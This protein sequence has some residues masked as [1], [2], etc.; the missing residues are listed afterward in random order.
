MFKI[1]SHNRQRCLEGSNK[2][3]CTAG[4]GDPTETEPELCVSVS[5]GGTV[6][7][8]WPAIGAGAV[9]LG[10]LVTQLVA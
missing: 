8:Q 4:L 1:K 6:G 2:T 7:Q 9:C 3:L 5:G 10:A